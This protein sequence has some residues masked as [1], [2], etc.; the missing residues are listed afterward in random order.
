M[1]IRFFLSDFSLKISKYGEI[2]RVNSEL[3]V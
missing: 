3:V 1:N 2:Y